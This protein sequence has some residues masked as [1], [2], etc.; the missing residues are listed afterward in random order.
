MRPPVH[1]PDALL[2]LALALP[3][4]LAGCG[5]TAV[6]ATLPADAAAVADPGATPA[7]GLPG[8][9]FLDHSV[10]AGQAKIPCLACHVWADRSPVAGLPSG[11]KCMGC[12]RFVAKD[13]PGVQL[14]ARRV[15][16]GTP[17][18]WQRVFS[19]PDFIY[20]S[21]RAHVRARVDCKECHGDMTWVRTIRQDRPFTMGRCLACHEERKATRDCVACHK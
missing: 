6:A 5:D 3:A 7:P 17:L 11:R 12:H 9:V 1:A 21:H 10:H 18:R 16:D 4:L 8:E 2:A 20:F 13:K 19:V 14:L 15:E